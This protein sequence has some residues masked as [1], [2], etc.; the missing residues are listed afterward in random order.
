MD[1]VKVVLAQPHIECAKCELLTAQKNMRPFTLG[2]RTVYDALCI[3]C[4]KKVLREHQGSCEMCSGK[5]MVDR[6]R[7]LE[8][9]DIGKTVRYEKLCSK[10]F[11][12]TLENLKARRKAFVENKAKVE[13]DARVG[14]RKQEGASANRNKRKKLEDSRRNAEQMALDFEAQQAVEQMK[15]EATAEKK[16]RRAVKNKKRHAKREQVRASFKDIE[17]AMLKAAGE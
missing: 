14:R 17:D 8:F 16:K 13:K 10:C 3:P 5:T 4:F 11:W 15:S 1:K 12:E 6:L 7:S 9:A 2:N